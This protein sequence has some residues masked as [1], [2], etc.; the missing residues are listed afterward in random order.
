MGPPVSPVPVAIL[1]TVPEAGSAAHAVAPA[2]VVST[3]PLVPEGLSFEAVIPAAILASVTAA[4]AMV[5]LGKLPVKSP[6]A[7][8]VGAAPVMVTLEAFVIL[9]W[10][11]TKICATWV[12]SPY[13]AGATAV[14]AKVIVPA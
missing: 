2:T 3:C 7:A 12:A 6:P 13:V 10:A 8:P 1:V 5:G 11:S 4:A 9:P 14:F